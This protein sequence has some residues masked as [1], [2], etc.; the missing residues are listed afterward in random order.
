MHQEDATTEKCTANK[1][2]TYSDA[3]QMK[4]GIFRC[5]QVK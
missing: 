3:P 4:Y 5:N 1:K 2:N